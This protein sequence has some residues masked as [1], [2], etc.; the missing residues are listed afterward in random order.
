MSNEDVMKARILKELMQMAFQNVRFQ[1]VL[2]NNA[3]EGVHEEVLTWV[4]QKS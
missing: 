3:G 1:Y 2:S 4:A